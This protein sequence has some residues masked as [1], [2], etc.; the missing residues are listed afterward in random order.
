MKRYYSN[1]STYRRPNYYRARTKWSTNFAEGTLRLEVPANQTTGS[2]A[3]VCSNPAQ[4]QNTVSQPFTAARVK[5]D[6]QAVTEN[7]EDAQYLGN[8]KVGIFYVTQGYA[9]SNAIFREH[10][11]WLMGY[12]FLGEPIIDQSG[13]ATILRPF[14]VS[15]TLKRKLQTGDAIYLVIAAYNSDTANARTIRFNYT[16]RWWTKAN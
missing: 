3:I 6:I 16:A 5:L 14:I 12:K 10:P 11:E 1:Y 7:A 13:S 9:V 4:T 8:V 2:Y 15:T